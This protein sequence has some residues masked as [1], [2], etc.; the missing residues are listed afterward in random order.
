MRKI[1][2]LFSLSLATA[3]FMSTVVGASAASVPVQNSTGD[4]EPVQSSLKL[5]AL[6]VE[7]PYDPALYDFVRNDD[8]NTVEV[9]VVEKASAR[10]V[11]TY[12]EIVEPSLN[13][14]SM[15][16]SGT[17]TTRTVYRLFTDRGYNN[18]HFA[19][20]NLYTVYN[21]WQDGSFGQI[22][23]VVGTYWEAMA[24]GGNFNIETNFAQTSPT[25]S[26]GSYPTNQVITTGSAVFATT[27]STEY[28]V[29][30]GYFGFTIGT[31]NIW[32]YATGAVGYN[33]NFGG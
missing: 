12:G 30:I 9:Q 4:V 29:S 31:S 14:V 23:S 17:Y 32:R 3:L 24:G 11:S 8:G 33:V 7:T 22:N 13:K 28:G 26:T 19:G 10:I 18:K 2:L 5:D 21:C 15:L 27:T 16:A 1:K 25:G 20:A 6:T